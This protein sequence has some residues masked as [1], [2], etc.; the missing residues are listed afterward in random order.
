MN[1]LKPGKPSFRASC[2]DDPTHVVGI[3][4]SAGGLEALQALLQRFTADCTAFVVVMHLSPTH[5][6]ALAKILAK[7]TPMSVTQATDSQVLRKNCIYVIPPGFQLTLTDEGTLRLSSLPS[8]YPRWTIDKF[9]SSL[10]EIGSA[11]I[12]VILSGTGSDGSQGLKEIRAKGGTTFVQDPASAASPQMPERA[13]PFA[14]YCLE[15]SALGDALMLSVGAR[16]KSA[17]PAE[18]NLAALGGNKARL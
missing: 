15:P 10:S 4:A 13:R 14:D 3:G 7:S 2:P 6:S 18:Q 17:Q 8:T 1:E 12:G 5:D 16:A 11:A 9:L